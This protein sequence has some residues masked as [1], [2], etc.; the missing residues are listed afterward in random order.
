MKYWCFFTLLLFSLNNYSQGY[1]VDNKY[2]YSKL[3][4]IEFNDVKIE[5]DF[6]NERIQVV[7]EV[8]IPFLLDFAE[9]QGKID[10]FRIIAGIKQG[11]LSIYNAPDSE[12]YK[13]IEAAGYSFSYKKNQVLEQRIDSII[14][15]IADAQSPTGYLYTQYMLNFD[16]PAA[17]SPEMKQIK[18]FGFGIEN[19]WN[20]V[21]T[22]W[23][24]AYN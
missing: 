22:R 10:N 24:F 23:P 2:S 11:K 9:K 5:D 3:A 14:E 21:N 15:D 20:S 7:Q 6:W 19:Q 16:H 4:A 1:N 12:I 13:L 17:P 8:T 18:R